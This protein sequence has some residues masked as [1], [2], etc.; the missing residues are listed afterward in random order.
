MKQEVNKMQIYFETVYHA[1][2]N[3]I[4]LKV[5]ILYNISGNHY[6]GFPIYDQS[7]DNSI[8]LKSIQKYVKIEEIMDISRKS[9]KSPVYAKG[10]SLRITVGERLFLNKEVKK[11]F[12][13][14]I[15][16]NLDHRVQDDISCI[17]WDSKKNR[18]K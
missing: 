17:K 8:C 9:I 5:L 18:I 11:H 7:V 14:K 15:D 1:N 2:V 4:P 10:Q 6:V 13:K 12:L 3:G 16:K